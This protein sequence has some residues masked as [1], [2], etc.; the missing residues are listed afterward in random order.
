MVLLPFNV[1]LPQY[2]LLYKCNLNVVLLCRYLFLCFHHHKKLETAVCQAFPCHKHWY[3]RSRLLAFIQFRLDMLPVCLHRNANWPLR[4]LNKS[5]ATS[6]L[7]NIRSIRRR[8]HCSTLCP[9][10][11]RLSSYLMVCLRGP[12]GPRREFFRSCSRTQVSSQ[13][14]GRCRSV[15]QRIVSSA[16]YWSIFQAPIVE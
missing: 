1:S 6:F 8:E 3:S 11:S 13:E 5:M 15:F 4:N 7:S 12:R 2:L 14:F 16:M 9:I 10:A